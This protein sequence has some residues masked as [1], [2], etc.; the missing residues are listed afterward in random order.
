MARYDDSA[1]L[2]Y[3]TSTSGRSKISWIGHSR[4]TQ[5]LFYGLSAY[6]DHANYINLF[7][8]LG[9]A[10]YL[11][12]TKTM[13]LSQLAKLDYHDFIDKFGYHDFLPTVGDVGDIC[14]FCKA[15]CADIVGAIVGPGQHNATLFNQS[16]YDLYTRFAP[17]GTSS[18]EMA[19]YAQ[20]VNTGT[21][22]FFDYGAKV[23]QQRYGMPTPPAYNLS[24]IGFSVPIA[25]FSGG[26]DYL[27]DPID[28]QHLA[29]VLGSRVILNHVE[30]EF[31]HMAFTWSILA[32]ERIYVPLMLP[33]LKQYNH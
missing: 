20:L 12:H 29:S 8:A 24:N 15:C 26:Q 11:G 14:I 27:A 4:G 1:I 25:L 17:A 22:H 21:I 7:L 30:Q 10:A 13:L 31:N 33:L 28:V 18:Q 6:P 32:A 16:R 3:I 5:Q 19:H 9:P 23:N 2:K